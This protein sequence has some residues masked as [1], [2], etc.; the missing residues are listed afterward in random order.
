MKSSANENGWNLDQ[1]LAAQYAA[2]S[3]LDP[4]LAASTGEQ[5]WDVLKS[6]RNTVDETDPARRAKRVAKT[7]RLLAKADLGRHLE[8]KKAIQARL[9]DLIKGSGPSINPKTG[10]QEFNSYDLEQFDGGRN[11]PT[12]WAIEEII[13]KGRQLPPISNYI[14][15]Y[16]IDN[17][18]GS[19]NPGGG[20]GTG[21][22]PSTPDPDGSTPKN[23]NEPE[24]PGEP[25]LEGESYKDYIDRLLEKGILRME[26]IGPLRPGCPAGAICA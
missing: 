11:T 24:V 16:N 1:G 4:D 3:G 7:S 9:S 23:P 5:V 6:L 13:A 15:D 17:S 26:E 20:G 19:V 2:Q 25:R 18:P 10:L 22:G 8:L 14:P 21:G 12:R